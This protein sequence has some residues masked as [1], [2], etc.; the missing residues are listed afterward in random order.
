MQKWVSALLGLALLAAAG[1]TVVAAPRA[2]DDARLKNADADTANWLMYGRTYSEQRFSPLKDINENTV[3]RLG[4]AW[5]RDLP[6]TRGV[7]ATPVVVDGVMYTTSTWSVVYAFDAKTG[8]PIWTYDPKADR[9]RAR[10]ICC[11]AVNRGV[12]FYDGKVYV[13]VTDGR[14][15]ALDSATGTVVWQADTVDGKKS[16]SI[17]GAPR[18]ANG[19]VLIGNGG[20]ED[21]ARGYVSAYDARTGKMRWRTYTVPGNPANGFESTALRDAAKTWKGKWWEEGGGGT[22][23]DTI[24]YDPD[25][26]LV[27]IGT[28]N[29]DPWYRD[30]RGGKSDNLYGTSI[31][32][33]RADTGAMVWHYQLVPGD[34]FDFDATQPLM[35]ADLQIGGRLRKVIMQAPKDGFFYILDRATGEF[36]SATPFTKI[37]WATGVDPKT[38]R[39]IESPS[40]YNGMNAVVVVPGPAGAHNWNPMAFSPVTRLVY[41]PAKDGTS[42]L[43]APDKDY[44]PGL[45]SF[46][47]GLKAGYDGPM[48]KQFLALPPAKGKLLAWNPVEKR[49]AWSVP[50][51]T[52]ESGGVLATA[53]NLVFQGRA[54]GMFDAY[55]ATDGKPLWQF[56]GGTGIMAAPMTY[57]VNGVQY[58]TVMVGWGGSSGLINPPGQGPVKPGWGRILTF[59]LDAKAP[60]RVRAYGHTQPP[61]PP[62]PVTAS[63]ATIKEGATLYER[64][65]MLCHGLNVVAGPIP[66]LR[67]ASAQTHAQ[68]ENI[69]LHGARAPLGMP[70]FGDLLT[71]AQAKAI[72]QYVLSRAREDAAARKP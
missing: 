67:Y 43:H 27:Y 7:E 29:A 24:V 35:L 62:L 17:T 9:S 21:G 14:L 55:R 64:N 32:A 52:V 13:G 50:L 56:D 65:C 16:Y 41:I 71:P 2:V 66:D 1:F 37:T 34:Q 12:A 39:P 33:L 8:A 31:L 5:S 25:L 36:L 61:A 47:V 28:G 22:V 72:Q 38:G 44:K 20:A 49:A 11:D 60:L 6:T 26:K 45:M 54:D 51:P 53:G 4:L 59:A 10:T 23:W 18:I 42:F 70:T 68:F 3:G 69:L 40:A 57:Q 58:L 19:L 15:I 46:N 30:L 48:L 63:A